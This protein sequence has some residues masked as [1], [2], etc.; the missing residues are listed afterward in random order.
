[1]A[2]VPAA[3]RSMLV[4][5]PA[6]PTTMVSVPAAPSKK[7]VASTWT[8]AVTLTVSSPEVCVSVSVPVVAS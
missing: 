1:M 5:A 6:T 4:P 8:V 2:S 3:L 7:S